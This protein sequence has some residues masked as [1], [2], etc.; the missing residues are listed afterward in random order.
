MES[1]EKEE[2]RVGGRE[3]RKKVCK[4][5]KIT[6]SASSNSSSSCR[7]HPSFFVCRRHDDQK[8]IFLIPYLFFIKPPIQ[9]GANR[10][11]STD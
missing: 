8:R 2:K 10:Q 5:C 7:F 6:F 9:I 1:G 3:E 11:A 4:R